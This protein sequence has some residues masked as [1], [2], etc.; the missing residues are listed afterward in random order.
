MQPMLCRKAGEKEAK[1]DERRQIDRAKGE[2]ERE[3]EQWRC[4]LADG[5]SA[6]QTAAG[7]QAGHVYLTAESESSPQ[8]A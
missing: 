2:S 4:V 6:H 5:F 3:R 8:L 7:R 1:R